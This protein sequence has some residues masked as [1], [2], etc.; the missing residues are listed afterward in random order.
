MTVSTL[1]VKELIEHQLLPRVSKP[2]RYLG[3]ALGEAPKPLGSAD[4]RVLI[5]FPDAYEIGLSNLG[6]RILHHVINGRPDAACELAFAPW[7]DAEAEM[8]RIGIPLFSLDS[9]T[10]ASEFDVLGFSLQYEL[11]YTNVLMMLELAGLPL[12]SVDR[13]ERHPLVIAGGAQAFSPEPMAEFIDAFVIGDGEEVIHRVVELVKL[14]KRERMSRGTL[15]R[16]LAHVPG[17]Y[18]PSGYDTV[19]TR[20]G[21]LVPRARPGFPER[22]WSAYVKE[23]KAEYYPPMPLVPVGEITHDRLSVEVMRGCTRGCRFCQAGMINRPVREKPA[24]QVVG[25]VLRGLQ[26][27]GLEEVSLISLSTTDHTQIVEQVNTLADLLCPTRVQLSLPSTRPDNVPVEVA[28]RIAAQKKGTITLAP[29]A[30]SQRMR[31]VINKNHT[32]AELLASVAT[33]AREGYTG[34][35]LYFMCGL[36]SETDDDL[37]AI[38]DLGHKAWVSAR[39]AGNKSFRVTV[40]VSPHVPKPHTPFAWAAQVSTVE[41]NRRL[42]ILREAVR[43][44]PITLKYRDAETSLLEGVFTRGDRRLGATI[45]SAYRRGCRFDAWSEHLR[46]ATWLD[47]FA[48][49]GLDPERYLIE[50]DLEIEQPWDVVQ[51]PVTKKFLVRDKRRADEAAILDDCRLEDVCFSCGVVDCNQRPWVKQPHASLDLETVLATLPAPAYGRRA[52]AHRAPRALHGTS[53]TA[54]GVATSTRFRIEF[55]KGATMRF[56]SHLDLMRTWE[57]TLRRSG[58]PLAFSQGHHPHIKMSFGPPLPLGFRS[59][60]EVFDLELNRP[61]GVDLAERL[62]AVLPDG[63]AVTSFRPILYKTPSLMSQLEGA[64]YRVRFPGSFLAEAGIVPGALRSE[65]DDRVSRL[66][67]RDVVLVRRV[68]EDKAREFDAKPSIVALH[69]SLD[70]APAV[71]DLHLRFTLRAAARPDDLIGL[72]VPEADPRTVDVE[73]TALWA[74]RGGE[75]WEPLRLLTPR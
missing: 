27:T 72:L 67:A 29:E 65:L 6:I 44:R 73:R 18:V 63:L 52:R 45:E 4:V 58:L 64:S 36:P 30:G 3:S 75:R 1:P 14:G 74:E 28:R 60:A 31:D 51:S 43:G 57:R 33:A 34:A 19:E 2:N 22:V 70:E 26:G 38:I 40:S 39:E 56:L 62:N 66:L 50:R 17:V 41:L 55:A 20:E 53:A 32:E 24:N 48:S 7:P 9:H 61:P 54:G 8:R 13:D 16:R 46:F 23:L 47:V 71:L 42:G 68:S 21:W 25:E 11:Q 5:A 12:R 15:L 49:F 10:P 35:K 37:K 69:A 59:R